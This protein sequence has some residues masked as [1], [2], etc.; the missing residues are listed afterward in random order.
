[1]GDLPK[2]DSNTLTESFENG[3]PASATA[4][5][6][7]GASAQKVAHSKQSDDYAEYQ[8]KMIMQQYSHQ[9]QLH[10]DPSIDLMYSEV[11]TQAVAGA[12]VTGDGLATSGSKR[13]AD[14]HADAP[15]PK[16]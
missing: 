3:V 11:T 16:V 13:K 4:A 8:R 6:A 12:A 9:K 15:H 1:M 5:S 14:G 10:T 7:A 2:P